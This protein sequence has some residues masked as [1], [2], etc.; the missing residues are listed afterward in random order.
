MSKA[1]K[2]IL[3]VD[4]EESIRNLYQNELEERGY[5]VLTAGDGQKALDVLLKESDLQLVITDIRHPEPD[6]REL[7]RRIKKEWPKMPVIIHTTFADGKGDKV[8]WEAEAYVVKSSDVD[9][10]LEAVNRVLADP[11]RT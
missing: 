4:D 6:G 8:F 5:R 2:T 7:I 9:G 1:P 11:S 3:L 10:L